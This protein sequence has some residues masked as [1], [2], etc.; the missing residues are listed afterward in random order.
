MRSIQ[1]YKAKSVSAAIR[2]IALAAPSLANDIRYF[3]LFKK[4]IDRKDPK[5]F[6]EHIVVKMESA[7]ME[8]LA[9][10][11]D[12]Y[13]VREYVREVIGEQ[14]LRPL[15]HVFDH[16]REVCFEEIPEG[17]YIKLNHGSGYNLRYR[18]KKKW[19]AKFLIRY[20]Y[21]QDFTKV[22]KE[23]Q[24]K[25]IKRKILVEPDITGQDQDLWEYCFY[26]FEG[27]TE[28]VQ[29]RNIYGKERYEV[30]RYYQELPFRKTAKVITTVEKH[31]LFDQMVQASDALASRFNFVRVDFL[32]TK[33]H[34]YFSELTF[35]PTAGRVRFAPEEY[36]QVF[37]DKLSAWD[38]SVFRM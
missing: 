1:Y 22:G 32:C 17:A 23:M 6:S 19:L 25:K 4:K 20:W 33:D 37:G 2:L 36:N 8:L 31:A 14:Y 27:K 38:K 34:F 35:T 7:E 18:R 26:T 5:T 29:I 30:D 12:K 13:Q 16:P 24:Y 10:Y 21:H 9:D 3:R 28:F 15:L 11:A